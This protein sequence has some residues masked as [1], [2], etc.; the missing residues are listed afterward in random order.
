MS[1]Q[2]L[3]QLKEE[4]SRL[5]RD[6]TN[7]DIISNLEKLKEISKR[8]SNI[9]PVVKKYDELRS[10]E[11][12]ILQN[13]ELIKTESDEELVG[14]AIEDNEF[15]RERKEKVAKELEKLLSPS[16]N[17]ENND[18]IVEIRA[19]TG[20]EE[21]ALFAADLFRM[22]H[23]YAEKIG[24]YS[25]ILSSSISGLGG[26][27][28]II[29]EIKGEG[30]FDKLKFESG[31]HRVQRVPKTEK[32]GRV[33]TS[34]STVA[35]LPSGKDIEDIKIESKDI[36]I[37][38]FRASGPGGQGVNTTDSA[39][40][41]T[42]L[43]TNMVVSCQDERSQLKNKDKAMKILKSR[44]L[45]KMKEDQEAK[46]SAARKTQIKQ[47]KRSEKIRTY[48]FPQDRITDHRLKKNWS[49]ID[50]IINGGLD[51]IVDS[52]QENS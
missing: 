16:N 38:I 43:P 21:A 9:E 19:G 20:G 23:K 46:E 33:H 41:I 28:E 39:V 36:R 13:E 31:V 45:A 48:N 12:E 50:E 1:R 15:L 8:I 47:A 24:W 44:L 10:I 2:E 34:T 35:V 40:R 14:I 51:R 3:D 30:V 6:L 11:K 26:F 29:L 17:G 49:N 7:P 4:Y 27:K 37:D 25:N 52:T 5:G 22:Y 18:V 32:S 42:H